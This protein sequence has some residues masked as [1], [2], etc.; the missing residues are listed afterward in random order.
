MHMTTVLPRH[1]IG[2]VALV[3]S[4]V[5]LA[6]C[7]G[8]KKKPESAGAAKA[9]TASAPLPVLPEPLIDQ[10]SV[11]AF[12]EHMVSTQGFDRAQLTALFKQV[13]PRPRIVQIMTAPAESKPWNVYRR[14][15]LTDARIQGGVAFWHENAAV[16]ARAESQYGVPAAI[17]VAIIGVETRYGDNMGSFPVIDALS[18]LAFDYPPR[19]EYF[20]GELE[21]FLLLSREEH[22]EPLAPKGSYAGAMGEAQFM[23]GSYR[24]FSVD[25]DGDGTRDLWHSS[26][27]AIGS[28]ANYLN[29]HGWQRGQPIAL[30]ARIAGNGYQNLLDPTLKKPARSIAQFKAAGVTPQGRVDDNSP[31][32]LVRLETDDA[33]EYWLGLDNFY[34][35]TRYNHSPRYAMAVYQLSREIQA[36][37]AAL[38]TPSPGS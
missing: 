37:C 29:A 34:A 7:A 3:F 33:A 2:W 18:T 10:N 20:R 13:Q 31:A 19:A 8:L 17:I 12:I 24:R 6:A 25:F 26:A 21:Q 15:F 27:D 1:R 16:L 38:A 9:P 35:I 32:M 22:L 5:L 28:I 4:A 14:I 30:R 23:P 36:Q 11:Q